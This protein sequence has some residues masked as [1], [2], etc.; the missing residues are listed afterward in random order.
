[1]A[2]IAR[3]VL[4]N[5]LP[6]YIERGFSATGALK[7]MKKVYG[8]AYR[9]TDFLKDYRE[10]ANIK[11]ATD[12]FKYIRKDL[13]PSRNSFMVGK[14]YQDVKYLFKV[15]LEGYDEEGNPVDQIHASILSDANMKIEDI[16][17]TAIEQFGDLEHAGY[18]RA[19]KATCLYGMINEDYA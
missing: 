12:V 18:L 10:F 7:D 4:R 16:E 17:R 9:K 2:S 11:K 13:Y 3:A 19:T 14:I 6:S 5:L 8:H 1:M 15:R